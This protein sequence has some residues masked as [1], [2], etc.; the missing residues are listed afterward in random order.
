MNIVS[1]CIHCII[2]MYIAVSLSLFYYIMTS[3]RYG[4]HAASTGVAKDVTEIV[5]TWELGNTKLFIYSTL[6]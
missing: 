2:L 4:R 6:Y 1:L 5:H 3:N